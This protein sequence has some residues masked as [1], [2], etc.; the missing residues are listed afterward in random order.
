MRALIPLAAILLAACHRGDAVPISDVVFVTV[1]TLRVDHVG[2]FAADSPAATPH[3]D[4]LAADSVLYEQAYSPISV[5]G[6]AFCTLLTGLEPS[7]HGVTMNLFRGGATL[8]PEVVTLAEHLVEAGFRTGAFVS[9]FTLRHALQLDQ[10]FEMYDEPITNRRRAGATTLNQ[11]LRWA[12]EAGTWRSRF[13]WWHTYDP[14]GPLDTWG[15]RPEP[16]A[17]PSDPADQAHLPRYQQLHG[18]TSPG[19]YAR[20]YARAVEH[21]DTQVGR[22]VAW[23]REHDRYD[24]ALIVFTADHGETF[25]ERPLWFDHGTTA[26]EEQL[27]VP[28]LIKY[29]QGWGAGTR[30]ERL[31]GLADIAPTVLHLESGLLPT[32]LDGRS[33]RDPSFIGH[34][35]LTGESSHCKNEPVLRCAPKGPEGKS[36]SARSPGFT[37]MH[38]PVPG[39]VERA[40]YDRVRDRAEAV[41]LQADQSPNELAHAIDLVIADRAARDYSGYERPGRSKADREEQEALEALGYRDR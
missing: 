19:F 2:A 31:V 40:L 34:G 41:P 15:D 21:T 30:D 38:T 16:G 17:W 29:P 27:H 10:G 33:L 24:D 20:R 26:H 12:D 23:L 4:A 11:M 1:D 36:F 8:A 37:L 35:V 32:G 13:L 39:G 7:Q 22:V 25:T 5:T 18:V 3:I 14:H 6:P 28:L 9:G